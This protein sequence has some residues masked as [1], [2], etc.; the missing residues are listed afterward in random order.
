MAD[1]KNLEKV[2]ITDPR[3][4]MAAVAWVEMIQDWP[5]PEDGDGETRPTLVLYLPYGTMEELKDLRKTLALNR[6]EVESAVEQQK[7]ALALMKEAGVDLDIMG[8]GFK[9]KHIHEHL[10]EGCPAYDECDLPIRKD[11]GPGT[12]EGG[13]LLN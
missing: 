8:D 1:E 5:I 12:G 9:E 11:L 13:P 2:I 10:C 7:S 6:Q 4:L 3:V